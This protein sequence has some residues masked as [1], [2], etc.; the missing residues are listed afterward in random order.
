MEFQLNE[1]SSACHNQHYERK[2]ILIVCTGNS[3]RS[4]M[5]EGW[6]RSF[7]ETMDVYSAGTFPEREINPF[8]VEVMKDVNINISQHKPENVHEFIDRDFDY[9]ITVC[10][11]ARQICPAFKGNV[12]HLLHFGFD[13]PAL[14]KGSDDE[15]REFYRKTRDKIKD[16]FYQFYISIR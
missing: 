16:A 13:D 6:M 3:C 4:Q 9:F 10:D 15:I 2:R 14:I 1:K 12:K 8:A 5:A 7:D 11:N